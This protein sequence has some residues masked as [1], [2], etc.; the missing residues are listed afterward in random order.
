MKFGVFQVLPTRES[1]PAVVAAHAEGLG[2]ESYWVPDHTILPV[3]YS[4]PYPGAQDG[5]T[6]PDYLW[7]MPDP[8]I[9][10][11]RVSGATRTIKLGTGV[12]LVPERHP[13]LAAK[14]VASLDALSNGRFLFGI[15]AG[16]NPE[17]CAILGG[18]FEHRWTQVKEFIAAMKTLWA[19]EHSE[20]HGKYVDFPPVRCFPKPVSRP[21]PPVLLGSINNAR[22]HKRIGEW[23]DGWLPIVNTIDEFRHGVGEIRRYA[24]DAGRDPSRLDFTAFGFDGKWR[25]ADE[26]RQLEAAGANRIVLWLHHSG[27]D[28]IR[29][30]LDATAKLVLG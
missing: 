3:N 4:V 15:G 23:G 1:D 10:L 27:L 22:A 28:D 21:W 18:D 20:F 19:D 9:T 24:A 25:K 26:I 2:F 11:A 16:W 17:E 6:E 7:Q 8:L 12:C 13:I 5:G 29:R 14:Q 30:E